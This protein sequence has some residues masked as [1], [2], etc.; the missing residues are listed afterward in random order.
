MWRGKGPNYETPVRFCTYVHIYEYVCVW[1]S[2]H[3]CVWMAS[4][5]VYECRFN[6]FE[7][8]CVFGLRYFVVVR[9]FVCFWLY[10]R[11]FAMYPFYLLAYSDY[12]HHRNKNINLSVVKS[13]SKNHSVQELLYSVVSRN[14][15]SAFITWIVCESFSPLRISS[16]VVDV[17]V[18]VM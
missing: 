4:A 11:L 9:L 10:M 8:K 3:T 16:G 15:Q 14:G 2:A 18:L 5:C 13:S 7:W 1:V 17:H 12:K 6:F